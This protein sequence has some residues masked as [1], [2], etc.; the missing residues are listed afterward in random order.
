[1]N[2]RLGIIETEEGHYKRA[3]LVTGKHD[4]EWAREPESNLVYFP[5]SYV[6]EDTY[7]L[8]LDAEGIDAIAVELN[9]LGG[10]L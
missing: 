9:Q 8:P 10:G 5:G 1:M 6:E 3:I 2:K 7:E 4:S